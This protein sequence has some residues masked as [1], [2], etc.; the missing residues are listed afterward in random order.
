MDPT[1]ILNAGEYFGDYRPYRKTSD[2]PCHS[3]FVFSG[4]TRHA[5][6]DQA[7]L[8][9][10]AWRVQFSDLEAEIVC[11]SHEA[12]F[13]SQCLMDGL[14]CWASGFLILSSPKT[15]LP[16]LYSVYATRGPA[17]HLSAKVAECLASNALLASVRDVFENPMHAHVN[18]T[19]LGPGL[20]HPTAYSV[21][22]RKASALRDDPEALRALFFVVHSEANTRSRS[23]LFYGQDATRLGASTFTY[24]SGGGTG[25][26]QR[27]VPPNLFP[28]E[29]VRGCAVV[30]NDGASVLSVLSALLEVDASFPTLVVAERSAVPFVG[31]ALRKGAAGAITT[32]LAVSDFNAVLFNCSSVV[33]VSVEMLCHADTEPHLVALKRRSWQRLVTVG[34]PQVSQELEMSSASFSYQTHLCLAVTEDLHLH[35]CL[36]DLSSAAALL[37]LSEG[38]MQDP[39]SVNALLRQRVF[40]LSPFSEDK[41]TAGALTR[42][43]IVYSVRLAPPVD[44]EESA[45]LSNYRGPKRQM[46]TLFGS[47]CASGKGAFS[48][49]AEGVSLLEHFTSLRVRLSPFAISQ[50]GDR[51]TDVECPVC[52]EPNPPVVTSCGHRYCQGCLQQSLSTQRRCPACR[53]PLQVRDVVHTDAKPDELGAYLE[54]L[55]DLLKRRTGKALVL[56]SWGES[57]ERIASCFRRKG[58]S[59]IW[60]WRGGSKQLCINNQ[61]FCNS[62]DAVLLVDPGS[63]CFSLAWASFKSVTEVF[64]LWPLNSAEG[65]DDVCCQLRRAKAAVPGARFCL[66]SRDRGATLPV[67]PTCVRQ[68]FP[69]LECSNCI[70]DGCLVQT[71]I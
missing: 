57:H 12:D 3:G 61:R 2:L 18:G 6:R 52:F 62:S 63:D 31:D 68:H 36:F 54:Y 28:G 7:N 50:L 17:K 25:S 4:W 51:A 60:A 44:S 24:R 23:S 53:S 33:L 64:V 5:T 42:P 38:A 21:L 30:G 14:E 9:S 8:S 34:W 55:F 10:R 41:Q 47:L 11:E 35:D 71:E 69:G 15:F 46:R 26:V 43:E 1:S 56:A 32:L 66:V 16:L 59:N 37:G 49:L 70:F 45:R 40:H 39:I 48:T 20:C 27:S 29:V 67:T 13:L 65:L 19:S 22:M 58:L